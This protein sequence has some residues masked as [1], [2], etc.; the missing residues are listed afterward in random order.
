MHATRNAGAAADQQS[1]DRNQRN[2]AK[3]RTGGACARLSFSKRQASCSSCRCSARQLFLH[4]YRSSFDFHHSRCGSINRRSAEFFD[5]SRLSDCGSHASL[6]N[7]RASIASHT[8]ARGKGCNFIETLSDAN[9][10]DGFKTATAAHEVFRQSYF[11]FRARN[12]RRV[13]CRL[14]GVGNQ[15]NV[16]Q[17]GC[18]R[19]GPHGW[20]AFFRNTAGAVTEPL[21]CAVT[22]PVTCAVTEPKPGASAYSDKHDTGK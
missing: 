9:D 3:A 21:A 6:K 4:G 2:C 16:R 19:L 7:G 10:Q 14:R 17:R 18:N 12:A 8:Y 13:P 5:R 22:E 20:P 1:G 11:A 15:R